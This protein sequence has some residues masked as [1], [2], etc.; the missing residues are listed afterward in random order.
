MSWVHGKASTYTNHG[1][2]CD[3]CRAAHTEVCYRARM[4]RYSNPVPAGLHGTYNAYTNYGCRC[5]ACR[6]SRRVRG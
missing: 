5:D 2:R 1:C 4:R 3:A 6:E